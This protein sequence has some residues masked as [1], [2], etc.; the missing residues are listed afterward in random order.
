MQVNVT[1]PTAQSTD[2]HVQLKSLADPAS[3]VQADV[4]QKGVGPYDITCTPRVGG[5][6]NLTVKVNEKDILR[7]AFQVFIKMDS[8][9]LGSVDHPII[10]VVQPWG[11]AL[12]NKQQ[13][14]VA[15]RIGKK[16]SIMET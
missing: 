9:Q 3:S 6:Q 12:N 5:Q 14:V 2:I 1:A 13:L 10:G 7:G 8:T 15:E 11:I 16:I 4:S